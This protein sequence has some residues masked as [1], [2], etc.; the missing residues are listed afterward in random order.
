MRCK[1]GARKLGHGVGYQ[2]P[3][4]HGGWV[5]QQYLPDRLVGRRYYTAIRGHEAE[6][7]T[8][9]EEEK[10]RAARRDE[11]G[12]VGAPASHEAADAERRET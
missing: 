7:A 10:R 2:Y 9:L 12:D 8:R 4:G 11:V 3:H 1:S 6:M 5:A